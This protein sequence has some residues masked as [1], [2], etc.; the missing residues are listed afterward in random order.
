MS[1]KSSGIKNLAYIRYG[2]TQSFAF[3]CKNCGYPYG[4]HYGDNCPSLTGRYKLISI[5]DNDYMPKP[6]E[7]GRFNLKVI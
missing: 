4:H 1:Y 5:F 2:G 3:I 6:F 7:D